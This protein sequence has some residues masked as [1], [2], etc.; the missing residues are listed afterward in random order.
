MVIRMRP[1]RQDRGAGQR[2]PRHRRIVRH[3]IGHHADRAAGLGRIERILQVGAGEDR[4]GMPVLAH[5]EPHQVGRPRQ[6]LQPRVGGVAGQPVIGDLGRDREHPRADAAGTP[7]RWRGRCCSSLSIG[8]SRSS[9][10]MI[11]TRFHGRSARGELGDRSASG[12]VPPGSAISARVARVDRAFD[13]EADVA[14][15]RV[16]QLL[17]RCHIPTIRLRS[18]LDA[19]SLAYRGG[20]LRDIRTILQPPGRYRLSAG[21]IAEPLVRQAAE[22][23]IDR[24]D[25]RCRGRRCI[26]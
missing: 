26:R 7:G 10:G 21:R 12:V 3:R 18:S 24:A 5:A 20:R 13:D 16:G 6:V 25:R 2:H 23:G 14:G 4:R 9:V 19:P 8:T 15:D 1:R 17:E 11:V 22:L